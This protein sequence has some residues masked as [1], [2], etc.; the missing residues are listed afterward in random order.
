MRM[1]YGSKRGLRSEQHQRGDLMSGSNSLSLCLTLFHPMTGTK[2]SK[3][4]MSFMQWSKAFQLR[5]TVYG[6]SKR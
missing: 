5:H 4:D 6:F 2:T 3:S 1:G